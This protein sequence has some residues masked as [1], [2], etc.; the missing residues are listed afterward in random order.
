MGSEMCIRDR[1]LPKK[2]PEAYQRSPLK[3]PYP[4]LVSISV[5]AIG[6][7]LYQSYLLISDLQLVYIIGTLVYII[8]AAGIAYLSRTPQNY[9]IASPALLATKQSPEG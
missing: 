8:L 1:R 3:V 9:E 4:L 6:L 2:Y 5:L 7:L